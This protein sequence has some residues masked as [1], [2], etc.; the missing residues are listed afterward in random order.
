MKKVLGIVAVVLLVVIAYW[1]L[2]PLLNGRG[3]ATFASYAPGGAEMAYVTP[4]GAERVAPAHVSQ[5]GLSYG[6]R[7]KVR[8]ASDGFYEITGGPYE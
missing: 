7:V 8:K 3:N 1:V 4:D 6:D 5:T 2:T